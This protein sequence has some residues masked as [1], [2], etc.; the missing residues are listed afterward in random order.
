MEKVERR[1]RSGESE[2]SPEEY[3]VLREKGTER[4][5][6]GAYWDNKDD[7]RLPLQGLR[8]GAVRLRHQVRLGHRLAELLR[9]D[10]RTR[11]SR[12]RPDRSL[13]M[14]RTEVVCKPLRRPPRPR[15][16]RRPEPTGLRYCINSCSLDFDAQDRAA[17][18]ED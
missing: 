18:A 5:F 17:S 1:S 2:L 15:L 4:A 14:R 6:T 7:G 11:R 9:A 12:P 3:D 8:R 13:F 16:R 10:G